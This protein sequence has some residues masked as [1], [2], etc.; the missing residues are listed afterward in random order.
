L[1]KLEALLY[2]RD[3]LPHTEHDMYGQLQLSL[4]LLHL[5]DKQMFNPTFPRRTLER[6]GLS[7]RFQLRPVLAQNSEMTRK[8]RD[9]R[10]TAILSWA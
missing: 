5:N 6:R 10:A 9:I 7:N 3:E 1:S 2:V 4:V 8:P